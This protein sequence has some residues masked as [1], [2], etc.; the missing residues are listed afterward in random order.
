MDCATTGLVD[1][2]YPVVPAYCDRMYSVCDDGPWK[3]MS[4]PYV[5]SDWVVK[6][7]I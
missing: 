7:P 6:W 1:A 3:I 5:P 2:R 4:A